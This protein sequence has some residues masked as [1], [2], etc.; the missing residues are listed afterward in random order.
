MKPRLRKK[1]RKIQR[2]LDAIAGKGV[3][4]DLQRKLNDAE[5][6]LEAEENATRRAQREHEE[7]KSGNGTR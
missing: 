3:A 1:D 5:R 7:T 4:E 2:A 6:R